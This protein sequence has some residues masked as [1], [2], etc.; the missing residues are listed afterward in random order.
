L[1]GKT[2]SWTATFADG[3]QWGDYVP[4]PP[5]DYVFVPFDS[6]TV[7][8][9]TIVLTTNNGP[10]GLYTNAAL[11]GKAWGFISSTVL[12]NSTFIGAGVG[13]ASSSSI[14]SSPPIA[15]PSVGDPLLLADVP[16]NADN[17]FASQIQV[18]NAAL[19]SSGAYTLSD[20]TLTVTTVGAIVPEPSSLALLG[21]GAFGLIGYGW[22]RKRKQAA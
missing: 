18:V 5:P 7:T 2:L 16:T 8:L 1:D 19:T 6:Y 21:I 15:L 14:G 3:A 22:R 20:P 13:L 9:D 12:A 17:Y 4:A 10:P 11:V